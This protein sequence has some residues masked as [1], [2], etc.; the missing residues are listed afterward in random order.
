M[1]NRLESPKPIPSPRPRRFGGLVAWLI[2][3]PVVFGTLIGFSELAM[4]LDLENLAADTRS[5]LEAGYHPWPYDQIPPI[6]VAAFIEDVQKELELLGTPVITAT[7]QEGAFWIPATVTAEEPLPN[8]TPEPGEQP[9]AEASATPTEERPGATPTQL[10]PS[11]TASRTN[12]VVIFTR[13]LTITPTPTPRTPTPTRTP[14]KIVIRPTSTEVTEPERSPTPT[15]T[16]PPTITVVTEPPTTYHVIPIAENLG[17]SSPDPE[18]QG[19]MAIFGYDNE[20]LGEVDIPVGDRNY[21]SQPAVRIEPG[22]SLPTHFLVD[23]ISPAFAVVWNVEGP[24]SWFL[25]GGEAV[26]Q[27]CNP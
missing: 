3:V 18:G 22:G 7:V 19:C 15:R 24:I 13:T 5:L 25:D 12:T 27:W 6:N 14:T 16:F 2:L 20:N 26:V 21:L 17:E 11:V 1:D 8:E 4:T 10:T 23:R 9:T